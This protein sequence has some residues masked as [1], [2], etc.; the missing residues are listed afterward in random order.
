MRVY[1]ASPLY[2]YVELIFR[3]KRLFIVSIVLATL[4]VSTLATMRG[5]NYTA[6][7]LVLLSGTTTTGYQTPDETQMGSIKYKLNI[8]NIVLK[9]PEFTK[10]ALRKANLDKDKNGVQMT[11]VEFDK[12]AK[13][14]RSALGYAAGENILEISCHWPT[15]RAADIINAFYDA[16]QY[17]V[18]DHETMSSTNQTV[19]LEKLLKEYTDREKKMM[20]EQ[21]AYERSHVNDPISGTTNTLA[22]QYQND[23]RALEQQKL[24]IRELEE[25]RAEYAKQLAAT[26]KDIVEVT[27]AGN[28]ADPEY[29]DALKKRNAAMENLT[30]LKTKYQDTHPKVKEA[31]TQYDAAVLAFTKAEAAS[32]THT[33]IVKK[34]QT[35]NP[36][37]VRLKALVDEQDAQLRG[38]NANFAL[39][40]HNAEEDKKKAELAGKKIY[41]Y[42]WLTDQHSLIS[43]IRTNLQTRLETAKLDEEREREMHSAEMTM[44]VK[45]QSEQEAGGVR[46]VLLYGAGPIL[47]IVIAFAFSLIAESLDHSLRTPVEVEK[48]LGKPVLAVL[49]RMDPPRAARR[50]VA[51]GPDNTRATLPPA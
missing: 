14:A 51:A 3:S 5:K 13:E 16:Y 2:N 22:N 30:D 6:T 45:P 34:F 31:Q 24:Q 17:D 20:L 1:G 4:I 47:G 44:I 39:S 37:Y 35:T 8:L 40:S 36:E 23:L 42:K 32:K 12:F 33:N 15:D 41:D 18:L 25:K 28:S 21:D 9:D 29:Q 19:L 10:Q 48:H 50:Q 46:S 7:A 27:T 43:Q 11:E 26:E 49:P 38:L